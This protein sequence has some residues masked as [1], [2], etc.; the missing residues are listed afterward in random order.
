MDIFEKP[1]FSFHE[2][3][4]P[5]LKKKKKKLSRPVASSL[6]TDLISRTRPPITPPL[7]LME[8]CTIYYNYLFNSFLLRVL[9][10]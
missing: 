1:S 8:P 5:A 10:P 9:L 4:T 7:S 2:I 6:A 3:H